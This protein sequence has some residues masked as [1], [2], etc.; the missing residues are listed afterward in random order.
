MLTRGREE[1]SGQKEQHVQRL[2]G[3]RA[4][5][6]PGEQKDQGGWREAPSR[7]RGAPG[8]QESIEGE[9]VRPLGCFRSVEAPRRIL[10]RSSSIQL[11]DESSRSGFRR[12]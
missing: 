9:G 6:L 4:L 2:G 5:D 7:G 3:K 1:Y 10:Q 12:A 8:E 11:A